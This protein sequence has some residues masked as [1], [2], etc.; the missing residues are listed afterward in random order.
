MSKLQKREKVKG[1]VVVGNLTMQ[2]VL[3]FMKNI[4]GVLH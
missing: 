3:M 2:Y 1:V 4:G